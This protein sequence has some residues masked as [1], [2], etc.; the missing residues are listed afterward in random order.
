[1]KSIKKLFII[2]CMSAITTQI[3]AITSVLITNTTSYSIQYTGSDIIH[4]GANHWETS[5]QNFIHGDVN[6][7]SIS[8]SPG[9]KTKLGVKIQYDIRDK[10]NQIIDSCTLDVAGGM[11][12]EGKGF[13]N[14][15]C[16]NNS[17][18]IK[19]A[20]CSNFA[21]TPGNPIYFI[22]LVEGNIGQKHYDENCS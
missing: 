21:N 8:G 6:Q 9:E 1:M 10:T 17:I 18:S 4:N 2:L 11:D 14:I 13:V 7:F 19:Q 5:P 22:T 3:W 20:H 12:R 15:Q 16:I